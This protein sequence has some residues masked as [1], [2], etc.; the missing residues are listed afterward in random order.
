MP[1]LKSR[2]DTAH[3]LI[4]DDGRPLAAG[5]QRLK[6]S[7]EVRRTRQLCGHLPSAARANT[8]PVLFRN[9]LRGDPSVRDWAEQVVSE[10][11]ADAE[12]QALRAHA[13]AMR[14]MGGGP[15][16]SGSRARPFQAGPKDQDGQ[17]AAE[18]AAEAAWSLCTSPQAHP[19]T[20]TAC[21]ASFLDC[22]HQLRDHRRSPARAGVTRGRA[23]VTAAAAR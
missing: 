18:F 12:Q 4:G 17:H 11:G 8:V 1:Q 16:V 10:P 3:G 21:R 5:L 22:F 7:I 23:C 14:A 19:V 9:Y 20:G 2:W 15:I 13:R 6:T